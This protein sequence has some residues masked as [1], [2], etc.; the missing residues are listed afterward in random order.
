MIPYYSRAAA[1]VLSYGKTVGKFIVGTRVTN[2]DGTAPSGEAIVLRTF[3]RLV[4][5]DPLS[6]PGST[7][8]PWHDSWAHVVVVD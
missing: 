2:P 8:Y 7:C 6:A 3:A 1:G 5:L 4:P